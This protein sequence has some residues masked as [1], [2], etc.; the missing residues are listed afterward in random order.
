MIG[1]IEGYYKIENLK[2]LKKKVDNI[3]KKIK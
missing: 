2:E 1:K 3:I